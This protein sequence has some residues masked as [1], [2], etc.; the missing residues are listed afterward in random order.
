LGIACLRG[1]ASIGRSYAAVAGNEGLTLQ[2]TAGEAVIY[3]ATVDN[4]TNDSSMS[5]ARRQ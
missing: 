5:V 3:G 2:I 1:S 4:T